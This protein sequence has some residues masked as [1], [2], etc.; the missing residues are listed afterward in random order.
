M[1]SFQIVYVP[2]QVDQPIVE[3]K[4]EYAEGKEIECLIETLKQ[5]FAKVGGSA[6]KQ[7]EES[8]LLGD[9]LVLFC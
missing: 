4:I 5:H 7:D 2:A 3:W 1:A 6:S 9:K 8:A